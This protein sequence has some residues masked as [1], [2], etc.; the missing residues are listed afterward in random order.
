MK[1]AKLLLA[2]AF[3]T[4]RLNQVLLGAE[5]RLLRPYLR[6]VNYHD[7]PPSMASGFEAQLQFYSK[8]FQPVGYQDLLALHQGRWPYAKPGIILT[9]DDGLRSH[10][11]VAAPLLEK[12]GFTGWFMV[13]AAFPDWSEESRAENFPRDR[14]LDVSLEGLPDRRCVLSWDEVGALDRRHVIGCHSMSHRRLGP[15]LSEAELD[16][17]VVAAKSHLENRLGHEVP[18]F[19]WIGG[20][21]WA[22]SSAAAG[23]IRRAG[24]RAAF[25]TNNAVFRAGNDLLQIQRSNVEAD[26]SPALLHF[27]LSGFFDVLYTAK[28]RRVN[29]LTRAPVAR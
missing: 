1:R 9:F 29:R 14:Q 22:Y 3:E 4:A 11:L 10:A 25:M 17:E 16:Y 18:V 21:E 23:A 15:E 6:A 28:R 27:C 13:P 20:E 12:H 5:A 8:H 2:T 26:Y 19:A 7:V 24:F